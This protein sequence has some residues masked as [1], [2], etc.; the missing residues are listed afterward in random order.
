MLSTRA[1][2]TIATGFQLLA[3]TVPALGHLSYSNRNFGSFTGLEPQSFTITGQT[4]PNNWGWADGTD[5]DFGHSH[6]LRFFRFSLQITTSVAITVTAQDALA[7]LP[8]FSI[9]SGLAHL[10]AVGLDYETDLVF[11]YLATLPGPAKEG[12]FMATG[13]WRMGN[14]NSTSVNDFS[15]FFYAGNAAD[16]GASNYGTAPGVNGDGVA[17][18]TVTA[19]F[20]LGPGDYTLGVGGANYFGQ[21]LDAVADGVTVTVSSVPEPTTGILSAAGM[22]AIGTMRRRKNLPNS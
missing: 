18:G 15:T 14:D 8:A 20:L 2:K 12:A 16:G 10:P 1:K 19:T 3:F 22:L 9:Y 4:V 5:A 7:L 13:T 6:E 21:G 11:Q 17:D